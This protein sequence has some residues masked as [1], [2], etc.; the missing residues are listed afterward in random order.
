MEIEDEGGN[1]GPSGVERPRRLNFTKSEMPA[2]LDTWPKGSDP[3][4]LFPVGM[5]LWELC[6]VTLKR[7]IFWSTTRG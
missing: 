4:H 3:H 2:T 7:R 5:A 1:L 6:L